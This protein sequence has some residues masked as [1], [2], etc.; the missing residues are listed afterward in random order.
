[1]KEKLTPKN[2][3][4][5]GIVTVALGGLLLS[6]QSLLTKNGDGVAPQNVL[7]SDVKSSTVSV[8]WITADR[9]ESKIYFGT[10]PALGSEVTSPGL[11]TAHLVNLTNLSPN[12]AY[13]FAIGQNE[14]KYGQDGKNGDVPYTFRTLASVEN[15]PVAEAI[16]IE[17]KP[18]VAA[19]EVTNPAPT[20]AFGN[21]IKP[22]TVTSRVLAEAT[23]GGT[24]GIGTTGTTGGTPNG[25]TTLPTILLA[26]TAALFV[27]LGLKLL[28]NW[29][30][31]SRT[32]RSWI[33]NTYDSEHF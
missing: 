15:K 13:F 30:L 26:V 4:L 5:F 23:A 21:L 9:A 14:Q 1:M 8:S 33:Q 27:T 11:S 6:F 20:S 10:T 18:A 28:K 24:P 19:A 17:K 2:I 22:T 16:K 31:P 29:P 3:A 7:I 12:T 25:A 32:S